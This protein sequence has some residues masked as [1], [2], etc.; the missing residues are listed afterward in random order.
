M[1]MLILATIINILAMLFGPL[2]PLVIV[3]TLL[4]FRYERN[5]MGDLIP[6][7]SYH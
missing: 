2:S 5:D 1:V 4:L 3:S 6:D 7:N